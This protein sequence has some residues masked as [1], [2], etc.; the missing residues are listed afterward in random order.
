MA[1]AFHVQR[2][3]RILLHCYNEPHGPWWDET[4][5]L[6]GNTLELHLL[7]PVTAI[8]GRPLRHYAH[9]SDVVRLEALLE[10]GG[11]YL[12]IDVVLVHSLDV[13][14]VY[15]TVLAEE[16]QQ[17]LLASVRWPLR[18]CSA[19]R[20]LTACVRVCV[21]RCACSAIAPGA[22]N[23][24]LT[25]LGDGYGDVWS[26]ARGVSGMANAVILA[27]PQSPFLHRW[28]DEYRNFDDS[29]WDYHSCKLPLLLHQ[30]YP[31]EAIT[32]AASGF[33]IPQAEDMPEFLAERS[34][35][36]QAGSWDFDTN[37]AVHLWNHRMQSLLTRLRNSAPGAAAATTADQRQALMT[38]TSS[39]GK[40]ARSAWEPDAL[41]REVGGVQAAVCSHD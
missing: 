5:K 33:F 15:H 1:A 8:F 11:I 23:R 39:F 16:G 30:Q 32:M 14:R 35:S 34:E 29:S 36:S 7:A 6:C 19:A 37:W 26:R 24:V 3:E 20:R 2:P 27:V 31:G 41:R 18:A 38:A 13:L 40:L 22:L 25:T 28:Y 4:K 10:H 9:K 21:L 12:D 17:H